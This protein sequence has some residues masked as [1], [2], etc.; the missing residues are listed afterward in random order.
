M[1]KCN[2][3]KRLK[4]LLEFHKC[5]AKKDGYKSTSCHRTW[6]QNNEAIGG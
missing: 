1:K 4:Y 6:H 5:K 2:M 3:C